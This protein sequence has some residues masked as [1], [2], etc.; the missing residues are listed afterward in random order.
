MFSVLE[1]L[2]GDA[3]DLPVGVVHACTF[4]PV[5]DLPL[6]VSQDQPYTHPQEVRSLIAT[7]HDNVEYVIT[8][9]F[10][11]SIRTWRLEPSGFVELPGSRFEG[12]TRAVTCLLLHESRLWSGSMDRSIRVWNLLDGSLAGKLQCVPPGNNDGHSATITAL[13]IFKNGADS[14]IAS[15]DESG[16]VHV[17]E[18]ANGNHCDSREHGCPVTTMTTFQDDAQQGQACLVIALF[19]GR[20]FLRSC[21]TL[22]IVFVLTP[23]MSGAVS[24]I[25]WSLKSLGHSCFASGHDDGNIVIWQIPDPIP[26]C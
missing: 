6:R 25:I 13:Q 19:D 9:G 10:E 8:A 3:P 26:N 12:H 15:G 21:S 20:I 5:V 23:Q 22:D 1:A 18:A 24:S 11:G 4:N 17:W 7:K 16:E 14:Y 2:P